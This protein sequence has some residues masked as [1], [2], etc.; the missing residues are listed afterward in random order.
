M[1]SI[2]SVLLE[3]G[4]LDVIIADDLVMT[5][6]E[7]AT[8]DEDLNSALR[9]FTIS[10]VGTIPIVEDDNSLKVIG[11]LSRRELL[12]AYDKKIQEVRSY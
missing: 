4:V 11:M 8:L 12:F 2:R 6:I 3:D 1:D 7:V 10:N 5:N 9:K